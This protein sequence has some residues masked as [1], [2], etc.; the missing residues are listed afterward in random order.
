MKKRH[1][2]TIGGAFPVNSN[3]TF[4]SIKKPGEGFPGCHD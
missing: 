1:L 4:L 2:K 3:N